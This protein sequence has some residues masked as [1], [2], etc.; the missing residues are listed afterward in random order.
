VH[1]TLLLLV[2]Q[3]QQ[4]VLFPAGSLTTYA[5]SADN[6]EKLQH[7]VHMSSSDSFIGTGSSGDSRQPA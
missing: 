5:L 1:A 6:A 2:A 3:L 7:Y 4:Q